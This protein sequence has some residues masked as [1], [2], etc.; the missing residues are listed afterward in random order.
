[1]TSINYYM[2]ADNNFGHQTMKPCSFA[3]LNL[4]RI[5]DTQPIM[6]R[7]EAT[8][9]LYPLPTASWRRHRPWYAESTL[10]PWN[11]EPEY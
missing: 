8:T 2:L 7:F 4:T 10:A 3:A 9:L 1:M 5:K 6:H 11:F